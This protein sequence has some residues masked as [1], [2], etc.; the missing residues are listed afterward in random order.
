MPDRYI[1]SAIMLTNYETV[2]LHPECNKKALN[3]G[4]YCYIHC[5]SYKPETLQE[6]NADRYASQ[7]NDCW[8]Y[9]VLAKQAHKIKIGR[10]KNVAKRVDNLRTSCPFDIELIAKFE[11]D[12]QMELDLHKHFKA[13]R[14]NGEWF[15]VCDEINNM[16][17]IANNE[18]WLGVKRQLNA[19]FNY[20]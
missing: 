5:E 10:S 7:R 9:F 13:H 19:I 2:C 20:E 12:A 11:A 8:I 14:T 1:Q 18:G 3:K 15:K 16:A 4:E 6:I 17:C